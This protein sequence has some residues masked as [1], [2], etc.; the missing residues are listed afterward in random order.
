MIDVRIVCTHDALKL[1]EMLTR[2]LEAEEHRVRLTFGRQAMSELEEASATRDAVLLIWSPNARSQSYMLEWARTI[3]PSR[4]VELSQGTSDAP[5]LKRLAAV[6]DFTTWRGQRGARAWKALVDR[7]NA[8]AGALAPQRIPV[9]TFAAMG[10]ASAAA[11]ASAVVLGP[12]PDIE[13]I[14]APPLEDLAAGDPDTGLGGP[15]SALEPASLD[16]LELRVRHYRDLP[17]V[18]PLTSDPLARVPELEH[19]TLRDRTL[20]ENL[21][22]YNPLRRSDEAAQ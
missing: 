6:I 9:K 20:L 18:E 3:P 16:D 1:A 19:F 7:L 5:A 21:D 15:I 11:V 13:P 4:L 12:G 10:L 2:L 14:S 22:R 8:I 17:A